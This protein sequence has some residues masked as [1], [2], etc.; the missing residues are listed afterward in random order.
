MWFVVCSAGSAGSGSPGQGAYSARNRI[1]VCVELGAEG[2]HNRTQNGDLF[3]V[4]EFLAVQATEEMGRFI[5]IA[6]RDA[7]VR[8]LV[9]CGSAAEPIRNIGPDTVGGADNLLPDSV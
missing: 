9:V 8:S 7:Q 3:V 5:Q 2:V 1:E 6:A 4:Q